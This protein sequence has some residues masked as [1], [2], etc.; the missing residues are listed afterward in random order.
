MKY[1][2]SISHRYDSILN[3]LLSNQMG[4]SFTA[5][6]KRVTESLIK[7]GAVDSMEP[8]RKGLML[9]HEDAVDAVQTTKKAAALMSDS[10]TRLV[11][12]VSSILSR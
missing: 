10:V 6:T 9:I 1:H 2:Q 4:Y 12:A 11:Q 7:A 5:C 8:P 3:T